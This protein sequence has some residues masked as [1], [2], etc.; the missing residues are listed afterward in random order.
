MTICVYS[1]T[2]NYDTLH[3]RKEKRKRKV[4]DPKNMSLGYIKLVTQME[5]SL[6]CLVM[7]E[8]SAGK[9]HI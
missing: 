9:R 4:L 7:H 5:L 1:I 8:T 2:I 3:Y 6:C